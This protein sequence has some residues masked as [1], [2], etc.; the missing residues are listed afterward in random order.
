M[1]SENEAPLGLKGGLPINVR[2]GHSIKF[3]E[4][5]HGAQ[6]LNLVLH[7]FLD[8]AGALFREKVVFRRIAV[9]PII[10]RPF[11]HD[12]FRPGPRLGI[13]LAF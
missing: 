2:I 10:Q 13:V 4:K 9:N 12:D 11:K 1:E 6:R 5:S 3:N 8:N 7:G